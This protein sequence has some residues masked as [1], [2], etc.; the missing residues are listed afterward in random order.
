MLRDFVGVCMCV[1]WLPVYF[2]VFLCHPIH[3][4]FCFSACSS[5]PVV[6]VGHWAQG[7]SYLLCGALLSAA[8]SGSI[9]CHLWG[10]HMHGITQQRQGAVQLTSL[11][12]ALTFTHTMVSS[13]FALCGCGC[14]CVC[15]H[16]QVLRLEALHRFSVLWHLTREVQTNRST[17]LNRSFDRSAMDYSM[18][19]I[20]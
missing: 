17:S 8:L 7:A 12:R 20:N 19:Y 16:P 11:T 15:I 1:Q 18:L 3:L 9:C 5:G 6:S 10:H 13:C 2:Y 4:S 14:V